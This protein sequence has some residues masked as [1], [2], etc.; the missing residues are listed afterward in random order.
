MCWAEAEAKKLLRSI[1]R[2]IAG[3]GLVTFARRGRRAGELLETSFLIHQRDEERYRHQAS[4]ATFQ[5]FAA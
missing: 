2:P 1:P 5:D 4:P 3:N